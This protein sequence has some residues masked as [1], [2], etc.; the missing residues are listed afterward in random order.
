MASNM[1]NIGMYNATTM[2]PTTLPSTR[3]I[4]GSSSEESC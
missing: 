2:K 1:E 4:N 3:I